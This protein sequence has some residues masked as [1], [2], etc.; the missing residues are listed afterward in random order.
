[1]PGE[2]LC[3]ITGTGYLS[4]L[5][6]LLHSALID[7]HGHFTKG[8]VP[9]W[10]EPSSGIKLEHCLGESYLELPHSLRLYASDVEELLKVK[11]AFSLG[12]RRLLAAGRTATRDLS[13]VWLAGSLGRHTDKEALEALGFFPSG[14]L[15]RLHAAGN[16]S[17]AGAALALRHPPA[18]E[19]LKDWAAQVSTVNLAADP[20]FTRA[21]AAH[22]RFAW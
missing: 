16:S 13:G 4:L 8:S 3:G 6:L 12:L 22:M 20:G 11:A 17:L 19:A 10:R 5:R 21:F 15:P 9:V 18:R 14:F 7:R 2:Q 1:M